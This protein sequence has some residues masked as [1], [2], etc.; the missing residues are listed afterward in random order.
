MSK[1]Y[2][3][4]MTQAAST[5]DFYLLRAIA[6]LNNYV[7]NPEEHPELI[8]AYMSACSKGFETMVNADDNI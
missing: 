6:A 8:S 3:N 1:N 7:D 2:E 5:A 4:L